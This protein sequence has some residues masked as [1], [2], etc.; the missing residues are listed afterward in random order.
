MPRRVFSPAFLLAASVV[1][2]QEAAS[3]PAKAAPPTFPG[4]VEQVTVDVVV[5]DRNGVPVRD[6]AQGDFEVLEDGVP[7]QVV[8]FEAVEVPPAASAVPRSLPR[9]ST[10]REAESERGRTFVVLFD[11]IRLTPA[12][13]QRAKAAVAAFLAQG[14]REGDRVTLAATLAGTWWTER[15]ES[16]RDRL[17][18]LVRRL[19][20]RYI[21]DSA[22]ERMTDLEA[23][24]IHVDRDIDTAQRVQR[25]Y[26]ELGVTQQL[27]PDPQQAR[28]RSTSV[29]PYVEA[30][31]AQV[32]SQCRARTRTTLSLLERSLEALNATKG[33]KSLI[34]VSA[35][36][37][38]DRNLAEFRWVGQA[39][40]RANTAVYFVNA[41]GLKGMPSQMTAEF[42]AALPEIDL[43]FALTEDFWDAEGAEAIASE[44]GGFTVR[45]TNDLAAGFARIADENSSY[46][47]LGYSP[48]NA[49]RDGGFRKISVT[50]RGR[51]GVDVRAR[52][53]YYA[54]GDEAD[55]GRRRPGRDR[56]L[57]EA[58]DSP[59]EIGTI[60]L[61]MTHFVGAETVLG[62]ARVE[63][64]AEVDLRAVDLEPKEGRYLGALEFLL[65]TAQRESGELFRY[66][67]RIDLKLLPATREKLRRTWLPIRREFELQPGGH[68]AKIVV[69][70]GRSGRV[71]TVSHRFDVPAL[72]EFRVSTPVLADAD[73]AAPGPESRVLPVARRAFEQGEE[74]AC[75]FEVYGAEKD[76][77]GMPRV[78][79]GY[80]LRGADG[81]VVKQVEPTEILPTSLGELSRLFRVGLRATPPGDY[82]FVMA[83]VDRLSGKNL[84][85]KEPFSVLAEGALEQASTPSAST[86]VSRPNARAAP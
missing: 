40:R 67:Q 27:T 75:R 7:Q 57:Q 82:E 50:V 29:S 13:A 1:A 77:S 86:D 59:H 60:P 46:Y 56:A 6:L 55:A 18:D 36:F 84:V 66:D 28:F 54:P 81:S 22:R 9:V 74:I 83:F 26:V 10:N 15:M 71:A 38:Y 68:V 62:K 23:K 32:Y 61:R 45:D 80:A 41:E 79:M 73:G 49:A 5:V 85:L 21:P 2:A 12:M 69:R 19:D 58:L 14:V 17:V 65:V 20:G 16:G 8:S 63:V 64:V 3:P 35:G 30:R 24:R 34:L 72:G 33:R 39:A 52:K 4:R 44:S 37:I 78:A 43:G 51:K 47:L 25:R 48:A 42:G 53:G 31:A 11:D 70:D 76:R